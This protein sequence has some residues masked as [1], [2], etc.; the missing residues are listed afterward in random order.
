MSCDEKSLHKNWIIV[1]LSD[2]EMA[3][4]EGWRMANAMDTHADAVRQLVRR[5]LLEEIGRV[6]RA[7]RGDRRASAS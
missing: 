5:G 4:L 7:F 6:Y 1:S 2:R 3:A